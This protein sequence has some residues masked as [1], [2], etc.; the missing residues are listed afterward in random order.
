MG[1]AVADRL[2]RDGYRLVLGDIDV[3]QLR[4]TASE[5]RPDNM[6]LDVDVARAD[7]VQELAPIGQEGFIARVLPSRACLPA[8]RNARG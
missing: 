4:R 6:V 5:L 7:A 8:A 1:R 2:A 3:G